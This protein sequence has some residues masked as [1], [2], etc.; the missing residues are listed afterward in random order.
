[1]ISKKFENITTFHQLQLRQSQIVKH[2]LNTLS[3]KNMHGFDKNVAI[4]T[5]TYPIK[6]FLRICPIFLKMTC[7]F[8]VC[9]HVLT[10]T[11]R[12]SKN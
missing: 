11:S 10:P 4:V 8:C 1:M 6:G 7:F 3:Y 5:Y 2:T 9:E 12:V